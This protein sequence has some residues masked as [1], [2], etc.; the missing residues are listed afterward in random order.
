MRNEIPTAN[1]AI[2][3]DESGVEPRLLTVRQSAGQLGC[4]AAN[5]Y[6][7]INSGQL[8]IVRVGCCKGYRIDLQDIDAFISERKVQRAQPEPRS[9]RPRPRLKHVRL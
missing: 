4:S 3:V 8:P 7:L 6:A 5:I 9:A 1:C 2:G